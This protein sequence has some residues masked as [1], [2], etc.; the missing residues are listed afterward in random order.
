[1]ILLL[2]LISIIVYDHV[3]SSPMF[4]TRYLIYFF[5]VFCFSGTLYAQTC[6]APVAGF[7]FNEYSSEDDSGHLKARL[8]GVNFTDD[9][10]GNEGNAVFMSGNKFSYISLGN[11]PRLKQKNGSVSLWVK[12]EYRMWSGKGVECNPVIVT[13]Y[14][15]LDDFFESYAIYYMLRTKKLVAF[16]TQDSTHESGIQSLNTFKLN[17][18]HHLVLSYNYNT[19]RFYID[20]EL[21]GKMDKKFETKFISTDSVMIGSIANQRNDRFLNG[22][23]DDITFYDYVLTDDEVSA[24]YDAPNPNTAKVILNWILKAVAI[25][26][27]IYII[28]LYIW[29]RTRKA[30]KKEKARLE[31]DYKLLQ[32]ELRVNRAS[33]NPHFL[34]NSLNTLHSFIL[35]EELHD[36]AD[37][38]VK[39]SKLIRKT[40][41]SNMQESISL[42]LE[43]ELLERYLEIENMRF[44]ENIRYTFITTDSMNT[45]A[46]HVPIMMLQP[47][48]E[49]AI[50]HGLLK[51]DG[52]KIITVSFSVQ[53]EKYI[54]CEIEDNGAGR[55]QK[56]ADPV[57]KTSMAT[58]F[59]LQ[60]LELLNKIHQLK[61]ALLIEDKPDH[62]GTIIKLT[63]PILKP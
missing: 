31:L 8:V 39:F 33:M 3:Q 17:Q 50:W 58:G 23:V 61:C 43:I 42:K 26:A 5:L 13:K 36:A 15:N 37:Y 55:R 47:F 51:K 19:L 45:S 46:L 28:Y 21:Q 11:D 20:G 57:E 27:I 44:E 59:I 10:F 4:S 30:V 18:W 38:L 60:R 25:L 1:M 63:L 12:I 34:F 49:N 24:L 22:A 56:G 54:Y 16:S 2:V 48:L 32:T 52:D 14:T 62:T 9:R 35:E 40:L 41:E 6:K 29:F 7:Y 53:K